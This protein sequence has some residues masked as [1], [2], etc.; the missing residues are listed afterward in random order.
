MDE[1]ALQKYNLVERYPPK[2]FCVFRDLFYIYFLITFI[3][4]ANILSIQILP[5]SGLALTVMALSGVLTAIFMHTLFLFLH[6]ASHYNL[7]PDRE[8]NDFWANIL[9]GYWFFTDVRMYRRM[10]W[11]HHL[12][13][14]KLADPENSYFAPLNLKNLFF[15][16]S[17]IYVV[18]KIV[19]WGKHTQ[20]QTYDVKD[21]PRKLTAII[22]FIIYQVLIAWPFMHY[23]AYL[24]YLIVWVLPL[25]LGFPFCGYVRQVC[26]H[27]KPKAGNLEYDILL[28]GCFSRVFKKTLFSYFFGAAGFRLHWYHHFNPHIS[29]TRLDDFSKDIIKNLS[30]LPL[31]EI[32]PVS[33]YKTF[34]SLFR[35]SRKEV[36]SGQ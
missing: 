32:Q 14:G 24:P 31:D 25:L 19:A 29:Y 28:H 27:R 34:V 30:N 22:F 9:V 26:E 11:N 5:F 23:E 1:Q 18:L 35:E 36:A 15:S 33:Y 17:G 10:H 12:Q 6:E 16:L 13:H 7:L 4:A 2:I 20:P 8:R 3:L 21:K